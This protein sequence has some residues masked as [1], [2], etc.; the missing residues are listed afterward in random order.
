MA[1]QEYNTAETR[2]DS[3]VV[4]SSSAYAKAEIADDQGRIQWLLLRELAS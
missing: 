4:G 1:A 3:G 2:S